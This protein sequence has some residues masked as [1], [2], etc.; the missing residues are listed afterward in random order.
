MS[1]NGSHLGLIRLV[2][3]KGAGRTVTHGGVPAITFQYN[4]IQCITTGQKD[5]PQEPAQHA[6]MPLM[7]VEM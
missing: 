5:L 4:T 3:P 6:D 1:D 2:V 7:R